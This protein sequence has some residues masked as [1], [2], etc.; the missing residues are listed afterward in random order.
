[1][2]GNKSLFIHVSTLP[3]IG[4]KQFEYLHISPSVGKSNLDMYTFQHF[5]VKGNKSLFI[6]VSTLL[7]IGKKQFEGVNIS[8]F[9]TS[10]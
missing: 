9:L 6:H 8:P 4:K 5:C 1:V 2:K 3:I 7:I 10:G